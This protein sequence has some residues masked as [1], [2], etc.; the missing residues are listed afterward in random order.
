MVQFS[1]YNKRNEWPHST[2]IHCFWCCHPFTG[3][4]CT[5]P[6]R[7]IDKT[8]HV[9][10][11]FCTPECAASYNFNKYD[12][13]SSEKYSLLNQLYRKIYNNPDYIVKLAPPQ[14]SLRLFGGHLSI[15]EFRNYNKNNNKILM[16]NMPPL[17]SIIPQIEESS[18]EINTN[19]KNSYIPLDADRIKKYN[20]KLKLQR[21]KPI[22]DKKNTLESC[23]NLKYV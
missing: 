1:E 11:N 4:P 14:L 13:K 2:S 20:D 12:D 18:S 21:N 3:V 17:I 10:G 19:I 16:L 9:F 6:F 15:D 5:L 8:Y 7:K 22:S 23:M